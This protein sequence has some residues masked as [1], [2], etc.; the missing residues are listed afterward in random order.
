MNSI[1]VEIKQEHSKV[2]N[3][4]LVFSA[5]NWVFYSSASNSPAMKAEFLRQI[6]DKLDELNK[7]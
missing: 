7:K 6:A 1:L 5:G 2:A 4:Y 3:G